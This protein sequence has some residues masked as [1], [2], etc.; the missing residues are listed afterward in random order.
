MELISYQQAIDAGLKHYFTGKPCKRGHIALRATICRGCVVCRDDRAKAWH[1]K[2]RERRNA[3]R[4]KWRLANPE[5]HRQAQR[6]SYLKHID[7]N[8]E[9]SKRYYA[10]RKDNHRELK[11]RWAQANKDRIQVHSYNSRAMR[12]GWAHEHNP[13]TIDIDRRLRAENAGRCAYCN[14]EGRL[15]YEHVIAISRNGSFAP[16]NVV[17]ACARCNY[18]KGLDPLPVFLARMCEKHPE[19]TW[20]SV[21]E[22]EAR[23]AAPWRNPP[24]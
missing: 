12:G 4:L 6:K 7:K 19:V 13:M 11:N 18:A 20:S 8:R 10:G 21:H 5:E 2:H 24:T 1:Q 15:H 22:I 16:T 3:A 14:R 23:L 17:M 9:R